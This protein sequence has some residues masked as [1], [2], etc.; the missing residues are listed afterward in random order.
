MPLQGANHK[1]DTDKTVKQVE[2]NEGYLFGDY[3]PCNENENFLIQLKEYVSTTKKIFTIHQSIEKLNT[4]LD[5]LDS[6]KYDLTSEMKNSVSKMTS[7]IEKF[8]SECLEITK[9]ILCVDE[10]TNA[11]LDNGKIFINKIENEYKEF[12]EQMQN[13]KKSIDLEIL[14]QRKN[15]IIIHREWL[16]K[17]ANFPSSIAKQAINSVD[18]KYEPEQDNYIISRVK[19]ILDSDDNKDNT[20]FVSFSFKVNASVT[21]FLK[22]SRKISDLGL[23]DIEIPIGFRMSLARRIK[24]TFRIISSNMG[25]GKKQ[26]L[27]FINIDNYYLKMIKLENNTLCLTLS[28]YLESDHKIMRITYDVRNLE[29]LKYLDNVNYSLRN[30]K[31]TDETLPRIEYIIGNERRKL[32]IFQKEFINFVDVAKL[33]LLGKKLVSI[34]NDIMFSETSVTNSELRWIRIDDKYVFTIEDNEKLILYDE[35]LV[36]SFLENMGKKFTPLLNIVKIKSPNK[37]ELILRYVTNDK[38]RKEYVIKLED[39]S[40]ELK[41][42]KEG[43]KICSVLEISS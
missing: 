42:S 17:D 6:I 43:S 28:D 2:Q 11:L 34:I 33:L 24:Q 36:M 8:Q 15:S 35:D 22:V 29:S 30:D 20:K 19:K 13:Y 23:A 27:Q 4:L 26:E 14:K 21:D 10:G 40:S 41:S 1:S 25:S 37:G 18:I 9:E 39:I 7:S 16:C 5:N 12:S 3:T 38:Q 31:I 32:N